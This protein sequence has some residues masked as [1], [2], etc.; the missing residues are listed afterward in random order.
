LKASLAAEIT[1]A[2]LRSGA[3]GALAG[4][5]EHRGAAVFAY[6]RQAAGDDAAAV[7]AEAFAEFR[8]AIQAPGSLTNG[9]QAEALLRYATLRAALS[10]LRG[11]TG[12]LEPP[13]AADCDALDV[14]IVGFLDKSLAPAHHDVVAAHIAGCRSCAA[15]LMRLQEAEPAFAVETGRPLPVAVAEQILTALVR[16]APVGSHGGDETAVRDQAMRLLTGEAVSAA[17]PVEPPPPPAPAPPPPPPVARASPTPP[18]NPD[19]PRDRTAA[20]WR[21]PRGPRLRLPSFGRA[22]F[23]PHRSAILLRGAVK[24]VAVVAVASAAGIG[25]GVAIAELTGDDAPSTAPAV[26]P[27]S[28]TPRATTTTSAATPPVATPKVRVEVLSATA[29][30]PADGAAPGARL[31]VGA[32]VSNASG[33][34]ITPE[35]PSLLVDDL[36]VAVAPESSSTAA[37]LLAPSLDTGATAEGTLRFDIPTVSPGD[38][39]RARVRMQIAGKFVVL[40][41]KLAQ[42]ASAG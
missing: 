37:A 34:A 27:T 30:P 3:P 28:S 13:P 20:S 35:R 25:L 14:E 7:A 31:T 16:A 4:L 18:P 15:L 23:G 38:L 11:G 41:P 32:R 8:R 36:S 39:T 21:S 42:S 17:A 9:E 29:R 26:A 40:S 1:P 22:H 12:L 6:C 33:R 24:L 19:P 2:K 10:Y 5:C